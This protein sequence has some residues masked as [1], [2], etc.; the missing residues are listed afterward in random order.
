MKTFLITLFAAIFSFQSFAQKIPAYYSAGTKQ[1]TISEIRNELKA[2]LKENNFK[3]LGGYY[4]EGKTNNYVLV[5]TN[6]TIQ[7]IGYSLKN[8]AIFGSALR[9]ALITNN[10]GVEITYLNPEYFF[11]G[12]YMSSYNAI[13]SKL[14][15]IENS[16]NKMFKAYG[17]ELKPFGGSVSTSNLT[18]YH[19]MVGMPYFNETI[20]LKEFDSFETAVA[21]I[22][23]NL[24]SKKG[25]TRLVYKLVY[26]KSK[27]A[28]YGVGLLSKTKGEPFFLPI[29]GRKNIAGLPYEI[30]VINNKAYILHGRFRFAFYWPNLTMGTFTKIM[31]TPGDVEDMMKEL[32]K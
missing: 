20:L 21:T 4:P 23:K 13:K 11:R 15:P 6:S 29:I 5:Y 31:S 2:K 16:I 1:G 25:D 24:N 14:K 8:F 22:G 28:V 12:Y 26:K 3:V 27:K 9:I 30:A 10:K 7:A 18:K 19:Y 32:T 17:G